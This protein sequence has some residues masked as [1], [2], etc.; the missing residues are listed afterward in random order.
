MSNEITRGVGRP[1]KYSQEILDKTIEY[2][3]GGYKVDEVIPSIAGLSVWL[4]ITRDTVRLWSKDLDKEEFSAIVA[5]ILA[6]QER[7][8]L[9][10]G[11]TEDFNASITKLL[12]TKHGYSDTQRIEAVIDSKLSDEEKAK[13]LSLVQ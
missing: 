3:N 2:C 1:T 4:G 10:G 13:L 9:K 7:T 8:L 6:L 12:L 11:L 5:E